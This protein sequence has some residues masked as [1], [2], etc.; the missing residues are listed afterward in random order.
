[1]FTVFPDA[2][3]L[4]AAAADLVGESAAAAVRDR[5]SFTLALAGGSTPEKAYALLVGRTDIDWAKALLFLGDERFVP[6]DDPRSN[7]GMARRALLDRVPAARAYPV[8]TD[9]PTPADAAASYARTL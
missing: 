6:P 4:A 5:G 8:P 2:D 1:M 7:L 3:R 9:L